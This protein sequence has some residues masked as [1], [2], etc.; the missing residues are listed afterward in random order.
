MPESKAFQR[1]R[2]NY[3]NMLQHS[4]MVDASL[5]RS[6]RI[7]KP[8]KNNGKTMCD[9]LRSS[10]EKYPKL[11]IPSSEYLRVINYSRQQNSEYCF[12]ELYNLFASYMKDILKEMYAKQP[13]KITEKSNK[14]LTYIKISEFSTMDSLVQYMIED[15]FR[16]LENEKSMPKLVEKI[17]NHTNVQVTQ[18]IADDA[19]MYLTIRH[20]IIHNNS[21]VDADFFNKYNS[22]LSIRLNDQVPTQFTILQNACLCIF[23]YL[24]E[25][26]SSL[27]AEGCIDARTL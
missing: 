20:L 2:G 15:I 27:I 7:L 21:K 5:N 22:K 9:N 18:S 17:M 6:Y 13:K 3:S 25:I 10:S 26:D 23:S 1:F 4:Q 14:Q 19:L 8:L 11:S 16:S 12:V 24:Q